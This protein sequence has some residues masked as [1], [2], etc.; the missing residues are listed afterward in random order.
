MPENHFY[1]W[2]REGS[3]GQAPGPSVIG[4]Q[5]GLRRPLPA[6]VAPAS[7]GTRSSTTIAR[8]AFTIARRTPS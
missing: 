7:P 4:P 5:T 3:A 8:A 6:P 1:S 2:L